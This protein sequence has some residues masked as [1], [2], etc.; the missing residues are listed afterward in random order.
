MEH[1][2]T[3]IPTQT[4]TCMNTQYIVAWK[5]PYYSVMITKSMGTLRGKNLQEE[6]QGKLTWII[7][8]M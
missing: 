2:D 8:L 5:K 4:Y 7:G 3:N 1:T 6:Q